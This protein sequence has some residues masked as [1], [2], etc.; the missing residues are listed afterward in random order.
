MTFSLPVFS[1]KKESVN[2]TDK[3]VDGIEQE[4]EE[5]VY[6]RSTDL[7]ANEHPS[8]RTLTIQDRKQQ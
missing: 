7:S 8:S 3:L 2:A 1:E 5:L 6:P 4:F